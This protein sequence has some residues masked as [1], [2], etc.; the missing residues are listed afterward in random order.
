[1]AGICALLVYIADD[2]HPFQDGDDPMVIA[3]D[4]ARGCL[5]KMNIAI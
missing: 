5:A 2:T 3:A 1:L 4:V